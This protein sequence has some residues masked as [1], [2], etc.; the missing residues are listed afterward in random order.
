L[1]AGDINGSGGLMVVGWDPLLMRYHQVLEVSGTQKREKIYF[2]VT[3]RGAVLNDVEII[4]DTEHHG[5]TVHFLPDTEKFL[6]T[7]VL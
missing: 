6:R 5:S 3:P 2:Q 4:G 7:I 1:G